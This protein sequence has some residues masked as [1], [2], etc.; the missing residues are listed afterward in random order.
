[1]PTEGSTT[2]LEMMN[3]Y[4]NQRAECVSGEQ[5]DSLKVV[6]ALL[7]WTDISPPVPSNNIQGNKI[8]SCDCKRPSLCRGFWRKE[9]WPQ[10]DLTFCQSNCGVPVATAEPLALRLKVKHPSVHTQRLPSPSS[11]LTRTSDHLRR[12]FTE[13]IFHTARKRA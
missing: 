4:R 8:P 3:V 11:L 12:T 9:S 2:C 10:S 13:V 7:I 1:M 6:L 5:L